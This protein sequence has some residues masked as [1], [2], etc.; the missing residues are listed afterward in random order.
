MTSNAPATAS[1]ALC[2]PSELID[3]ALR[4]AGSSLRHLSRVERYVESDEPIG[5]VARARLL[6]LLATLLAYSSERLTPPLPA[7]ARWVRVEASVSGGALRLAVED[8]ARDRPRGQDLAVL[9]ESVRRLGG[10]LEV[11]VGEWRGTQFL[12]RVA[13]AQL[14]AV[15]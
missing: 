13:P 2:L 15:A 11:G 14:V 4:L 1:S 12:V 6:G 8:G 10:T 3:A 9:A 7:P 5:P